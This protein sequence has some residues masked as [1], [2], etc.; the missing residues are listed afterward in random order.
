MLKAYKERLMRVQRPMLNA[1]EAKLASKQ[2]IT[3]VYRAQIADLKSV[4]DE[5]IRQATRKG[6]VQVTVPVH[7]DVDPVLVNGLQRA[8]VKMGYKVSVDVNY[9]ALG[10]DGVFMLSRTTMTVGW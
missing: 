5:G 1:Q 3:P 8:L 6:M 7:A 2:A 10:N 9:G 4:L